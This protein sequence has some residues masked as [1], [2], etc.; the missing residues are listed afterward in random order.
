MPRRIRFRG[1]VA[2]ELVRS[3][4]SGFEEVL[5][6]A[7]ASAAED[8]LERV[9]TKGASAMSRIAYAK[10]VARKRKNRGRK[11]VKEST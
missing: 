8:V 10:G 4:L 5:S 6:N 11:P 1:S 9:E 2:E 3:F 7:V